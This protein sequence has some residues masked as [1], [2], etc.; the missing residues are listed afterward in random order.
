MDSKM[1]NKMG[2]A[3]VFRL[4]MSM[5]IPSIIAMT[6]QALYNVVDSIFISFYAQ[7][8]LTAVTIAWPIQI[9]MIA[10]S[11]GTGIGINSL[12]SRRLGEGNR[13]DGESAATHGI[14]LAVGYT[15]LFMVFG[16]FFAE[17]FA[18]AFSNDSTVVAMSADYMSIVTIFSFGLMLQIT[19]DKIMQATGN[20]LHPMLAQTIGAVINIILDPIF[21]FGFG[22]IPSMGVAGAA[23]ATV[24]GQA[25]GMAYIL[26]ILFFHQKSIKVRLFG[27]RPSARILRDIFKVGLPSMAMQTLGSLLGV[28]L[29]G[30]LSGFSD[31]AVSAF[32]VYLRLNSFLFMPLFGITHGLLPI[33]GY[34]F[35][36][37]NKDRLMKA[38]KISIICGVILMFVG[39]LMFW[40][41]TESLLGIFDADAELLQYGVPALRFISI[42]FSFAAF[43]IMTGTM[44]DAV[45]QSVVSLFISVARQLIVL[46]PLAYVMSFFGVNYVWF[47]FPIAEVICFLLSILFARRVYDQHIAGL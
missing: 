12:I 46:I 6:V 35:G 24:T 1:H 38:Y 28:S 44:F 3:P 18:A 45:G 21:I 5:S 8:G 20:M 17:P 31:A 11:V 22:P 30:I 16:L 32:G 40:I 39:T 10:A 13:K 4:L 25:V 33:I 41:F 15:L 29:N 9:M 36:A 14:Y 37:R 2:T 26:F 7:E 23:I 27:V 34:N 43:S 47:A 19:A 42:G